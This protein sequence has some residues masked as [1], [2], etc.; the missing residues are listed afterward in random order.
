MKIF[1]FLAVVLTALSTYAQ[2][3]QQGYYITNNG[4]RIEGYFKT[5]DFYNTESL[6]FKQQNEGGDY[7]SID[8]NTISEYG[9]GTE[10]KFIKKTFEIDD[11][12]TNFKRL[13]SVS[14][15]KWIKTTGF[16]NVIIEGE[17]SLYSYNSDKGTKFFYSTPSKD[18]EQL[19]YK[20]YRPSETIVAEN[21]LYLQQLL[22]NVRCENEERSFFATI[23]YN[24]RPLIRAFKKYNECSGSPYTVYNNST[25]KETKINFTAFAAVNY[26][27]FG[28][29][30]SGADSEVEKFISPSL[31]IEVALVLPSEKWEIFS[32][33]EF[34]SLSA[35]TKAVYDRGFGS[36]TVENYDIDTQAINV[37]FGLRHNF[38]N[39]G[40]NKYFIDGAFGITKPFG[41]ISIEIINSTTGGDASTT[42]LKNIEL[43]TSLSGNIGVGYM[44]RNKFGV[45][46]RYETGRN[47]LSNGGALKTNISRIGLNLRY[48]LN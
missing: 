40:K 39:K 15:P 13:S 36:L 26:M 45:A 35:K 37:Q 16:L 8:V 17:A 38:I 34:E 43:E 1:T 20:R 33:V 7:S 28:I 29:K 32:R 11:S 31:G 10:F 2:D 9:I 42:A 27:S 47:M 25:G 21:N 23:D 19:L 22:N 18:V 41:D 30:G 4:Q 6:E 5:T 44:Y 48:T 3:Q 46:I 14:E 24:K 12:E